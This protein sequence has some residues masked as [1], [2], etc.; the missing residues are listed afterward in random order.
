MSAARHTA[1]RRV[2]A[3]QFAHETNTFPRMATDLARYQAQYCVF[4]DA[5]AGAVQ[6]ISADGGAVTRRGRGGC[7]DFSPTST[8]AEVKSF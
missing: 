7:L 2:L 8:R 6:D 5:V 3:P 4:G 1:P